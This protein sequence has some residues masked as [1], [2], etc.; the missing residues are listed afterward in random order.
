MHKNGLRNFSMHRNE[1]PAV[2]RS[3]C[4]TPGV[5]SLQGAEGLARMD[6]ESVA[7][8]YLVNALESE[9][10]P[11]FN[12]PQLGD[13]KVEFKPVGTETIPLTGTQT[14]KFR[15]FYGKV[16]V[17]GSLI[18]V[19]LDEQNCLLGM[20]SAM[21]EPQNI[22]PVAR[23]APAEA[24]DMMRARVG[25]QIAEPAPVPELHFYFDPRTSG[26]R[27][28]YVMQNVAV[29]PRGDGESGGGPARLVDYILDA[30]SGETVVELP[31]IQSVIGGGGGGDVTTGEE[32]PGEGPSP[33]ELARRA[34]VEQAMDL[35]GRTRD[36]GVLVE[37]A[38]K[39]LF[40]RA[41]NVRT[42]DFNFQDMTF[43]RRLLPGQPCGSP[44]AW[45]RA[46][47]SAHA[48][49]AEVAGFYRDVLQRD[50]IDNRGGPIISSINCCAGEGGREWR[51]A[52]WIGTQMVYGQRLVEGEM[53]SYAV[54][55]DVV[56]HELTHGVTENTARLEY[57]GASGALNESYS[58]IFGVLISNDAEPD[59]GRWNWQM[60][61]E[62]DGTGVPIRD[63]SAPERYG[64]PAHMRDYRDLPVDEWNDWGGVHTNSG[65]HNKAAFNLICAPGEGGQGFLFTPRECAILF[66]LALTQYLSRTS[67]FADSRRAVT[68]AAQTYFRNDPAREA[69]VRAVD[70]AFDAVGV[71]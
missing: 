66:Y 62:L 23:V 27:L 67:G 55:L 12:T 7:R 22:D 19:E 8:R 9:Q 32:T 17:Y 61:E 24:L 35:L 65:I 45:D 28:V 34:L 46:A 57:A 42:H 41:H 25:G 33:A 38:K 48:N 49:A 6:P 68:L 16:P 70:A 37:G 39:T 59:I 31:R 10:L 60:G 43:M 56:G 71:A 1:M 29:L 58:D 51:N 40:D 20:S 36:V 54:A 69:K 15:Q 5:P 26:W 64:Q 47:I 4:P 13:R 21:G 30:H 11:T 50:G 53:R 3:L 14:V 44:P 18:T 2:S 52:A 63:L